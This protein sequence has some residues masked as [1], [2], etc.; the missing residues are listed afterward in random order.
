MKNEDYY[1]LPD[2]RLVMT[3]TYLLKRGYCCG[4]GC[5]NCPYDYQQVPEPKRTIL[6][7]KRNEQSREG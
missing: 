6:L 2:G 7:E 4:N 1:I 3:A 5:M